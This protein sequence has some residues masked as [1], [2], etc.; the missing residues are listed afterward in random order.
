M[1]KRYCECG[2]EV[3]VEYVCPAGPRQ[4]VAVMVPVRV[5]AQRDAKPQVCPACGRS[6]SINRL[7]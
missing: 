2:Q 5:V 4:W 3:R 7:R 1:Q 6:L